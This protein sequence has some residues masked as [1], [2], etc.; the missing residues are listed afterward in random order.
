[1]GKETINANV[2]M[3]NNLTGLRLSSILLIYTS[4]MPITIIS[5]PFKTSPKSLFFV[6]RLTVE[7]LDQVVK[8]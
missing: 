5:Q 2:K 3:I 1:M 8:L 4:S 7:R 6:N